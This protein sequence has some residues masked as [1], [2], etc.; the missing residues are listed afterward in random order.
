MMLP[1]MKKEE[2]IILKLRSLFGQYGYKKFKM[3]KFEE[4]DFYAQSRNF[5]SSE[6]ILT[7]NGLDGKL[8]ALKP[9]ITLSI[10][11]NTKGNYQTPDRV[12]YTENVY[13]ARK[14]AKEFKEIMQVGVEYIG[15]VDKYAT[16]EVI[17][18]AAKSLKIIGENY[19]LDISHM[20]FIIGF[21]E[22]MNLSPVDQENLLKKIRE[23]NSHGI[24]EFC[25]EN[26]INASVSDDLVK[27]STLYGS[28]EDVISD[29]RSIASNEKMKAALNE[30]EF[31]YH[32]LKA[33]GECNKINL[34][35]SIVNVT[36]YYN[37]IIFQ[38]FIDGVP[39]SILSGGRYDNLLHKLNKKADAIGFAVYMDF[40]E[41]YDNVKTIYDVDILLLYSDETEPISLIKAVEMLVK[42]GQSILVQKENNN[43]IKYK[44]LWCMKDRGLEII[45]END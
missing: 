44:Q 40:L 28:V 22:E 15:D 26:D 37:G 13:R 16:I 10:V 5:L 39:S 6:A 9:D 38:G 19:I 25:K 32:G 14:G 41:R 36:D 29:A 3:S 33:L 34:D 31:V 27:I 45:Y 2:E 11:K 42:N 8:L 23:K 18:L 35:F 43:N 1:I 7:F 17:S 4:Y 24:V 30:I 21:M 20:G 12:Y